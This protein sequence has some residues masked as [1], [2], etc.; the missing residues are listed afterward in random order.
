M[1]MQL[2]LCVRTSFYYDNNGRG[3][4]K[5]VH[6]RDSQTTWKVVDKVALSSSDHLPALQAWME[7]FTGNDQYFHSTFKVVARGSDY[8]GYY[9]ILI[10]VS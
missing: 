5:A 6:K 1:D 3:R 4:I 2:G 7:K 9:F 10:P 8:E